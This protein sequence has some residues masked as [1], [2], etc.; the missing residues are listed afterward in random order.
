MDTA[1]SRT[2][3]EKTRSHPGR[4]ESVDSILLS[5]DGKFSLAQ[6]DYCPAFLTLQWKRL[7]ALREVNINGEHLAFY[8]EEISPECVSLV[9][10]FALA[11][12]RTGTA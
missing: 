9:S 12:P 8:E 1:S 2:R 7:F 4:S 5:L 6:L 10:A 3:A 11:R